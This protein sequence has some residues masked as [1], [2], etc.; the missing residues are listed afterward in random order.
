MNTRI[1]GLCVA[2]SF[3]SSALIYV[4]FKN[5][6]T[7][8][9]EKLDVLYQLIQSHANDTEMYRN[10]QQNIQFY[11]KQEVSNLIT[12][13][14]GEASDSGSDS[15]NSDSDDSDTESNELV[16]GDSIS[17]ETQI[18]KISLDLEEN[19]NELNQ[20]EIIDNIVLNKV[21]DL[22]INFDNLRSED[23][24]NFELADDEK[25]DDEENVGND[26]IE[27]NQHTTTSESSNDEKVSLD[28]SDLNEISE[29][30]LNKDTSENVDVNSE[31]SDLEKEL[32]VEHSSEELLLNENLENLNTTAEV[33]DA[34]ESSEEEIDYSRL[35]VVD[36]KKICRDKELTN[37]NSLKKSE[38]VKLLTNHS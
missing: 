21:K 27:A 36:L 37:Y 19:N 20:S 28:V 1:L 30:T 8:V 3:L 31:H 6:V 33:S 24:T 12:V 7:K 4:Y 25:E 2:M 32:T 16:I 13:S 26:N 17:N 18:K 38:L 35:R 34:S 11:P 29:F 14:D 22:D 9:D 15:D 23:V 10:Q 5:K